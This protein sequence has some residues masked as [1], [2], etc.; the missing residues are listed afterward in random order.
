MVLTWLGES[1]DD[2]DDDDG[3]DDLVVTI[4]PFELRL[5]LTTQRSE[6]DGRVIAAEAEAE[7]SRSPSS[8][9]RT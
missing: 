3:G 9:S 7:A 6:L 4:N 2:D 8:A 1:D 5:E